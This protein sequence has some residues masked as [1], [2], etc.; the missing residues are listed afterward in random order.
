MKK[1]IAALAFLVTSITLYAQQSADS[2]AQVSS[3]GAW[4]SEVK[5]W[6]LIIFTAA[7]IVVVLRTFRNKAEV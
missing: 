7:T 4:S 1:L 3:Q 6:L 2:V 5:T